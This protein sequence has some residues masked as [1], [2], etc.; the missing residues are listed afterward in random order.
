MDNIPDLNLVLRQF[1]I[2]ASL[3]SYGNGH[4]NDT[5]LT[6]PSGYIMQRINT[7]IFKNPDMLMGNIENVTNFLKEKIKACGGDPDR[8]T[9]TV[10][11]TL[12]GKNYYDNGDSC[13][14]VYKFINDAVTIEKVENP[15]DLY[16]AGGGFG[17]FQ[18]M[19][20]DFPVE[21]LND[22]IVD[23]HNTKKRV[24]LLKKAVIED[25]A[26]R[27]KTVREEIDF[28]L[29]YCDI[30]NVIVDELNH[31]KI[32]MRVTHNDTKINNILFS[33]DTGEAIAVI[34]LDTVMSGSALYDFGDALRIG[35]SSA[36]EDETDLDKVYFNV[37]YFKAFLRGYMEVMGVYLKAREIELLAFSPMLMTYEC[38]IRFLTDYLNGDTYFKIHRKNHNLDR[39]RNQFK[40]VYDI[41][42]KQEELNNIV[43][44]MI[45]WE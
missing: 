7:N 38:G 22:I 25:L 20:D 19:L 4:I 2:E 9:L 8:E 11:K 34:D 27:V 18:A 26:G 23:F 35:A 36:T 1:G 32:P 28:A 5:Y 45:K 43:K 41:D 29:G 6:K 30:A 42:K 3:E 40:L 12:D 14:R 15:K 37:D 44:E 16:Y 31:G 21:K 24:E 33:K 10:I 13:F 39:A 17:K